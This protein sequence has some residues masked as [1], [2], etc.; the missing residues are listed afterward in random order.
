MVSYL[1]QE[2]RTLAN[3]FQTDFIHLTVGGAELTAAPT[4]KQNVYVIRDM[5]KDYQ[6]MAV[7]RAIFDA[8]RDCKTMIFAETKRKVERTE[9]SS[10]R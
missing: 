6:L 4:I 3:E 8:S 7:L 5:D 2:V 9:P 10:S 1:A